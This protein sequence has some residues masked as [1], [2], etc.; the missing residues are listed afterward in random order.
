MFLR[1]TKIYK[2]IVTGENIIS[3]SIKLKTKWI[4]NRSRNPFFFPP[5]VWIECESFL[6]VVFP[7]FF[8]FLFLPFV[9]RYSVMAFV[10]TT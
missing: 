5:Y 1:K 7:I 9:F 2:K 3:K 4:S 6:Y 8:S 10:T